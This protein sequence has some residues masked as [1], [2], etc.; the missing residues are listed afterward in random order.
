M[1]TAVVDLLLPL[2]PPALRPPPLEWAKKTASRDQQRELTR[3]ARRCHAREVKRGG[4]EEKR[5]S[6]VINLW[7]L[8]SAN[9]VQLFTSLNQSRQ[10]T[11]IV[12][13][14]TNT[15][16]RS[17]VCLLSRLQVGHPTVVRH[18]YL[19]PVHIPNLFDS[20]VLSW[21]SYP[22]IPLHT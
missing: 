11:R 5:A 14:S 2:P 12:C 15:G 21:H 20:H 7:T 1:L 17:I 10:T 19:T 9:L 6:H 4:A 18:E 3:L 13:F 8:P 22:S 16:R